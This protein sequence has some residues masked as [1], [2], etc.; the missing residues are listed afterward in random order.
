M[1]RAIHVGAE[2]VRLEASL[3]NPISQQVTSQKIVLTEHGIHLY[4]IKVWFAWPSELD[5]MARLRG[6]VW[7][8]GGKT[9]IANHFRKKALGISPYTD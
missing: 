2:E 9:G 5:L 7:G 1:V 3:F 8:S 4:P 6:C